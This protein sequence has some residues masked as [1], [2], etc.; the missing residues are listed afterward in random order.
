MPRC[1]Q[2]GPSVRSDGPRDRAAGR[3]RLRDRGPGA[4][5]VRAHP[6][7]GRAQ[8]GVPRARVRD[9]AGD[10]VGP[11]TAA[12]SARDSREAGWDR[13][14]RAAPG[15]RRG[16][17]S[18]AAR[19]RVR[20]VP[21]R[22]GAR[23]RLAQVQDWGSGEVF[24]AS[25][26][27][28]GVGRD[29]Y[30]HW[31][32][33]LLGGHLVRQHLELA[34]SEPGGDMAFRGLFFTRGER[35]AGRVRRRPARDR[36]LRRRRA[37]ARRRERREPR[38]LRGADPDRPGRAADPHLSA[39]PLD[40]ALAE[41]ARS[42]RSPRCWSAPTTSRPRTAAPSASSTRTRSSTCRAAAS[43]ARARCG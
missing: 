35:A 27:F 25:T 32:P 22:R 28:V 2:A 9:L 20:A 39:V 7:R 41:G 3:D 40:A 10:F 31:L 34:V 23:C 29:A 4:T 6:D 12:G 8:S 17:R 5:S 33:A 16:R 19:G 43:T 18:G 30:C 1:G 26:H 14:P 15:F 11:D 24:D 42:T 13:T 38:E 21:E 36:P 37:L